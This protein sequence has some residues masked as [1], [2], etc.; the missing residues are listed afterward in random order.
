M[1]KNILLIVL[2]L[3]LAVV[4][5]LL[6]RRPATPFPPPDAGIHPPPGAPEN[7]G[8]PENLKTRQGLVVGYRN[9]AH[10]DVNAVELKTTK[11]GL[12]T[13]DFRPHTAR[14]VMDHAPIG[15]SVE[16]VT[17]SRPDDEYIVYQLHRIKNLRTHDEANLDALPPPPDVPPNYTAE[18]FTVDNPQLLTDPYGGIDGIR[19]SNLL[20]HFKPGLV[21]DIA[22]LIKSARTITLSAV[23]RSEDF[24][25]VNINHDKVY[26]VLSVTIDHKT[27]LVR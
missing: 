11:E 8:G 13:V 4:G 6:L 23:R 19:N 24:G 26:I 5:F 12:I 7:P 21:D 1:V 2:I 3:L 20:F 25:F 27:F 16:I 15:D 10:L 14:T 22:G 9:N 18:D 17:G